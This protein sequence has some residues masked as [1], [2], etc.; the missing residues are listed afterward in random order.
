MLKTP[1]EIVL[2][3]FLPALRRELVKA[4][5]KNGLERKEITKIFGLSEAA[6]CQYL[7]LKRGMNFKFNEEIQKE[8]NQAAIE[9]METKSKEKVIWEICRICTMLRRGKELCELHQKEN[10]SLVNCKL[11][12]QLIK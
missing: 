10:P 1:C 12:K 9:I 2:W 8:I 4:M 3:D 11:Y 6:I 5:I 7:K